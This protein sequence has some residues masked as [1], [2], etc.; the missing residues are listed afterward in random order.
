[1]F[2]AEGEQ[3]HQQIHP[4]MSS[5]TQILPTNSKKYVISTQLM[6]HGELDQ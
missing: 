3:I 2:Q 6:K 1:M 4:K 5:S